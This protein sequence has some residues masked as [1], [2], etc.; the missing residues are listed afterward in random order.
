M[1]W[2][3]IHS[4]FVVHIGCFS[5]VFIV[6]DAQGVVDVYVFH[7]LALSPLGIPAAL[8]SG[9]K[10]RKIMLWSKKLKDREMMLGKLGV[11]FAY[12]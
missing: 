2:V 7:V 11:G 9:G 1:D 12:V 6:N 4:T 5:D 3:F 10:D 8:L